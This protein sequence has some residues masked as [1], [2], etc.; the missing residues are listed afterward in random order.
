MADNE[1]MT[2]RKALVWLLKVAVEFVA[3]TAPAYIATLAYVALLAAAMPPAATV[4]IAVVSACATLLGCGICSVRCYWHCAS[5]DTSSMPLCGAELRL[6]P[7]L[8]L[9]SRGGLNI[10]VLRLII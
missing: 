8:R 10:S 4:D 7:R 9:P 5:I 1:P 3:I 2:W 6:D